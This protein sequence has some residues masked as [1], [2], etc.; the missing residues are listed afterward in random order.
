MMPG[1]LRAKKVFTIIQVQVGRAIGG[2]PE[3][4]GALTELPVVNL[5]VEQAA[6]IGPCERQ[7]VTV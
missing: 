1:P 2:K 6:Q 7:E 4:R 3:F 5:H